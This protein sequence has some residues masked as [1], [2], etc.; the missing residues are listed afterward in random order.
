MQQNR[1]NTESERSPNPGSAKAN[2]E[3]DG[4]EAWQCRDHRRFWCNGKQPVC[5]RKEQHR[6]AIPSEHS[7]EQAADSI[8]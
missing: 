4:Q 7:K 8:E 1:A 6:Y 3:G 2:A 5:E